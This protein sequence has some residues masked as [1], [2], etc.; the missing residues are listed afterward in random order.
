MKVRRL[1]IML[2][3][4][5][6]LLAAVHLAL[7]LGGSR[8]DRLVRRLT[9]LPE[10]DRAV[11]VS[12]SRGSGRIVLSRR[13]GDWR[14]DSPF[15]GAADSRLVLKLIDTLSFAPLQDSMSDSELLKLGRVRADFGLEPPRLAV[16]TSGGGKTARVAFG[17]ATPAEDGVYVSI[18]G[19]D[20]VFIAATNVLA[21][22]DLPPDGFRSHD[23]FSP[24]DDPVDA[25]DIR[26][27][28]GAFM[29]FAREGGEW[30]MIEPKEAAI[31]AERVRD[32]LA[33]LVSARA[34]EFIWPVGVSNETSTAALSLLAGFGLDPENAVSVSLRDGA[35]N[36]R[37]ASFGK[38]A[39]DGLVYAL[40]QNGGAIVTVDAQLSDTVQTES[41]AFADMRLFPYEAQSVGTVLLD[42]GGERVLIAKDAAGNWQLDEP[43]AAPADSASVTELV[44][45]LVALQADDCD[46]DGI[47]VSLVTNVRPVAVSREAILA[48]ISLAHLR[49]RD[50][51]KIESEDVRRIS[52]T[53]A[54][55]RTVSVVRSAGRRGWNV[56]KSHTSG[57]ADVKAV[58]ALLHELNPL[59]ALRVESLCARAS[60]LG[61]YGLEIP[62][63]TVAID[64]RRESDVR[65]NI[66]IGDRTEDGYFATLG[67][68]DAIFV[69]SEAVVDRFTAALVSE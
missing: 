13:S 44:A 24:P 8:A 29:R 45:R 55:G 47:L 56:E 25:F 48:S 12:I 17:S 19:V 69:L 31:S 27:G 34:R 50:I 38:A 36:D 1:W 49:S 43:V 57:T 64:R 62:R 28:K 61:S 39:G 11:S 65:R 32:F 3:A 21:A 42:D 68:A 6:A 40:I 18:D 35:G 2:L 53:P 46:P 7:G 20:S 22:V 26:C 9:L 5:S 16:E 4:A 33:R 60:D 51:L 63:Y 58:E 14:I 41:V 67:A 30:K 54:G 37:V 23:I 66:L 15:S 59:R 52:V 10:A